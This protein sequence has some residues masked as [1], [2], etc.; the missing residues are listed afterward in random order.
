MASDTNKVRLNLALDSR[1]KIAAQ[2]AAAERGQTV[3]KFIEQSID[4]ACALPTMR[5]NDVL[6]ESMTYFGQSRTLA[7]CL[8]GAFR[9][10]VHML[11][12][13]GELCGMRYC[14]QSLFDAISPWFHLMVCLAGEEPRRLRNQG[15]VDGWVKD[16][17]ENRAQYALD[18]SC[19]ASMFQV[20]LALVPANVE[21]HA[22]PVAL[23]FVWFES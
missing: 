19:D 16:L 17:V 20:S 12:P 11:R 1:S 2:V 14:M 5:L 13:E 9:E 21:S 10:Y 6:G 18:G 15:D 22:Q 23:G 7:E 3:T 8:S 4:T